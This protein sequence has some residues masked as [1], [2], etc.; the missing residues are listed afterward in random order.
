MEEEGG[1]K[2]KASGRWRHWPAAVLP[3]ARLSVVVVIVGKKGKEVFGVWGE[4]K[5]GDT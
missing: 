4:S 1:G 2:A 3:T 5:V